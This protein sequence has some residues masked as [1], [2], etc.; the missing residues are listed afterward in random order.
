MY[1]APSA[2]V[3]KWTS[4][5]SAISNVELQASGNSFQIE[6]ISSDERM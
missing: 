3:L 4:H 6:R 2:V 5:R 1:E